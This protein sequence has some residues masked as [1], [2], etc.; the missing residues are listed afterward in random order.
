M[1]GDQGEKSKNPLKKA[2]RRRNAKTVTF[3]APTY[4]EASDIDYSS[5]EE[6]EGDYFAQDQQQAAQQAEV[7]DQ[8]ATTEAT[9][10]RAE[11]RDVDSS[12]SEVAARKNGDSALKPGSETARTSD[13]IFDG[14]SEKSAK[15]RNGTVRNTDS[16]FKDDTVET[17]KITLTP[18]LL[19]DD[20]STSTVRTSGDSKELRQR[21]SIDK[22]EKD[23]AEKGKEDK[24]KKDKKEK[25]KKP[26]M[27]SNLFSR[28][29]KRLQDD[30]IDE[31]IYGK[32]NS[33]EDARSSPAPSNDSEELVTEDTTQR[34]SSPQRQPSKLQKQP[35][36]DAAITATN[37]LSNLT[38]EVRPA[39]TQQ[40]PAPERAPQASLAAEPSMRMVRADSQEPTEDV[41]KTRMVTPEVSRITTSQNNQDGS[42][43]ENPLSKILRARSHSNSEPKPEKVKKA[44]VRSE[45]DDFDSSVESSPIDGP[46]HDPIKQPARE[47][48]ARPSIPGAYPDSYVA[49]PA[50]ERP[51]P[52][53]ERLSESPVQVSPV[54]PSSRSNP[55]ALMV[56]TSSQ[57]DGH[58]PVS[59]PSPDIVD[60]DEVLGK[61][62]SEHSISTP[63]ST[64]TWNDAHLRTFFDD[65]SEI[66]DL[67]VVVYDKS[68]V[69][70]A[71][72]DHPITGNLFKEENAK[73]ADITS[74]SVLYI[75]LTTSLR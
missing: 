52:L 54:E 68:G 38:A 57:E 63:T 20:S 46:A 9:S 41:Q 6:G 56:D 19:R 23:P 27:L 33:G 29:K 75:T 60:V 12:T 30:D 64:S 8:Q 40:V 5:E 69:V 58:S 39:D 50:T 48:P 74:V 73:L 3:S 53:D 21:P 37:K 71:G 7:N 16:F 36:M 45:L 25:D 67:L 44:K 35:R 31:L 49:T 72:P 66:K 43:S 65:D 18:N 26:G 61:K 62:S 10:E 2:I 28:K 11:V 47:A 24:K 70:P 15:S 51:N 4:V 32:K 17:R 55:P 22:L 34:Q 14:N 59:S 1:L 13:E 42:K